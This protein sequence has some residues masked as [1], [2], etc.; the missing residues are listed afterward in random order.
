MDTAFASHCPHPLPCHV[1][2]CRVSS[3]GLLLSSPL[4]RQLTLSIEDA[5]P[6]L[7]LPSHPPLCH[8]TQCWPSRMSPLVLHRPPLCHITWC[9]ALRMSPLPATALAPSTLPH[10]PTSNI[11]D[12]PGLPLPSSLPHHLTFSIENASLCLLLP[13]QKPRNAS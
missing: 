8:I 11:E 9:W 13:Y 7:Q 12:A 2:Q 5:S 10:H 1:T 6:S 4:S 3:P